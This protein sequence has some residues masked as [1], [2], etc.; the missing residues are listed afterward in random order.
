[1]ARYRH[2]CF[3]YLIDVASAAFVVH[4]AVASSGVTCWGAGN[5]GV[6]LAAVAGAGVAALAVLS[7]EAN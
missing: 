3:S 5:R 7:A 2:V 1:M 6:S 4:S